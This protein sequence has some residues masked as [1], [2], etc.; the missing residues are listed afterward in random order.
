M[1]RVGR[2]TLLYFGLAGTQLLLRGLIAPGYMPEGDGSVRNLG[3]AA[4]SFGSRSCAT[5]VGILSR[6]G[7]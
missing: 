7:V 1:V 4:K 6:D 2:R 5:C 3:S